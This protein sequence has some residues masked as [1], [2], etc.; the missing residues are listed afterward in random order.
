M[1]TLQWHEESEANITA[2]LRYRLGQQTA[3]L[4]YS[5]GESSLMI[6]MVLVP[7]SFRGQGIG[8]ALIKRVLLFADMANLPTFV[9]ARPI[10]VST[11]EALERLVVYYKRLDF[12]VMDRGLTAVKMYRIARPSPKI[13]KRE[14]NPEIRQLE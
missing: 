2:E 9:L 14:L 4:R 12:V 6:K 11:A 10:G 7:P 13:L 8:T 1:D 3:M 5:E